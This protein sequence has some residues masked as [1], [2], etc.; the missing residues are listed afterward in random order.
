MRATDGVFLVGRDGL[1]VD[2][3]DAGAQLVGRTPA[4]VIGHSTATV[5]GSA[6]DQ[7]FLDDVMARGGAVT[8]LL[9]LASGRKAMLSASPVNRHA[10]DNWV[11]VVTHDVGGTTQILGRLLEALDAARAPW[12][13]MRQP[14]SRDRASEVVAVSPVMHA[15]ARQAKRYARSDAPILLLGET[16]SGKNVF[17][18]MIHDASPRSA[19]PMRSLNCGAIPETLVEAELFGYT[20]GAFTGA[21]P[22]GKVGLLELAHDG[23]LFLDE[24]GELPLSVQVKL[25]RFLE[26]G[27]VW[28]LGATRTRH[29]DV[30]VLAATN[31]DLDAAITAGTF[32]QDLFYRLSVLVLTVPPLRAHPDDIPPLVRM[33]L[34]RLAAGARPKVLSAEAM[35]ALTAYRFPGNVRELWNIVERLVVATEAETI[36]IADVSVHLSAPPLARAVPSSPTPAS[37]R[38]ARKEWEATVLRESLARYGTQAEAAKHL[39]VNQATVARKMKRY[40]TGTQ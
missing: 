30:R 24:L 29:V 35:S 25:L 38:E 36:E 21:D 12:A 16:G 37:L 27:E 39:G 1:I 31:R 11:L 20:R 14:R 10:G 33:M 9:H 13:D 3:N 2:V 18:R 40:R 6:A 22:K 15:I 8:R 34:A 5:L 7:G 23:T 17:A 26:T 4:D 19:G 32:R 28:P